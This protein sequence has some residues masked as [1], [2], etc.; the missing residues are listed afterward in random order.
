M[1]SSHEHI[2][3]VFTLANKCGSMVFSENDLS[4]PSLSSL[5]FEFNVCTK[6]REDRSYYFQLKRRNG[7]HV[8]PLTA[9]SALH[10]GGL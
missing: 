10:W 6:G 8:Q 3:T 7:T 5:D 4:L 1:S 9:I 2:W